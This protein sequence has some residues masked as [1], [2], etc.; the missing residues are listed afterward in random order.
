MVSSWP[1]ADKRFVDRQASDCMEKIIAIITAIRNIRAEMNI[2]PKLKIDV[3][4]SSK[5]TALKHFLEEVKTYTGRLS[6]AENIL[7]EDKINQPKASASS[8]LN[9]CQIYVPLQGK[10]DIAVEKARLSKN[11]A[12]SE[13]FLNSLA[14]KLSNGSFIDRAP[15]EIVEKERQKEF[16]LKEKIARIKETIENLA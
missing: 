9:F 7:I 13:R 11:L 6:G 1:K 5:D 14:K 8:I 2:A 10:V 4:I 12:E 15:K 3:L 16:V